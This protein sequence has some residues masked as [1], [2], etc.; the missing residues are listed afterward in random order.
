M[1]MEFDANVHKSTAPAACTIHDS[2]NDQFKT[3]DQHQP[4]RNDGQDLEKASQNPCGMEQHSGGTEDDGKKSEVTFDGDQDPSDPKSMTKARKWLIVLTVAFSSFCVTLNSTVYTSTYDQLIPQFRVSREVTTTGLTT[5]VLGLMTGPLLLAPFSE[6]YGRRIIYIA[7]FALVFV[8][9]I[10]CAV[11]QN[12]ET[13]LV[14][15]FFDGF[16]GSAFLS[17]AGGT[18]GDIFAKSE[19]S[20]PMMVYSASPF[21]GPALGGFSLAAKLC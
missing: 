20:L 2:R 13:I 14:T 21:V 10:P 19:L 11:A 8:F 7:S 4:G 3:S 15:R 17:V 9:I 5:F 1:T 6:F 18:I 16:F 12:I